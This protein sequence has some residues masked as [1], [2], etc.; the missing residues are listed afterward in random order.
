MRRTQKQSNRVNSCFLQTSMPTTEQRDLDI[1][2]FPQNPPA[3]TH[4]LLRPRKNRTEL[5]FL[6]LHPTRPRVRER[7]WLLQSAFEDQSHGLIGASG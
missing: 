4:M 5:A 6:G 3:A 1:P 2:K 7:P